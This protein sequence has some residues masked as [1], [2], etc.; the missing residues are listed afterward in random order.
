ME[1]IE[2][3]NEENLKKINKVLKNSGVIIYPTDTVYGIACDCY[4]EDGIKK[5]FSFKK[6]LLNK[7]INV[8]TDSIEKIETVGII[9]DSLERKL[10]NKYL[11]GDMTIILE[12]KEKVPDIL[13]AN[14]STIGVRIPNDP[15][16]LKILSNY[17]NPLATTSVNI[18]GES[19]GL[20]VS[21]FYEEFKDK[22]D[23]IIA[24]KKSKIGVPSTVVKVEKNK[25]RI[26]REGNLIIT[27]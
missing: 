20:E 19:P 21:D 4:L 6:R 1:I 27:E 10:I 25:V 15:I 3:L 5:L 18:S 24:G 12:K 7:P 13:T 8:L 17:P 22:V 26:L 14:L 11:P 2:K 16:A 23:L 9:N